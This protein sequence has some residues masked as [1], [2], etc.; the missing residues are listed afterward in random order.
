MTAPLCFGL[1]VTN[2]VDAG[3]GI[4]VGETPVILGRSETARLQ[5]QDPRVSRF[6]LSAW[7]VEGVVYVVTCP[8]AGP[9]LFHGHR[10]REARLGPGD[11]I[12]IGDTELTVVHELPRR[13]GRGAPRYE[14]PPPLP[15]PA[16]EVQGLAAVATLLSTLRLASSSEEFARDLRRA[17]RKRRIEATVRFA[18]G[19]DLPA[20]S[21]PHRA[22]HRV[23]VA[24][25]VA[26]DELWCPIG[27]VVAPGAPEWMVLRLALPV[28]QLKIEQ[29]LFFI[30]VLPL[31]AHLYSFI[32]AA[33]AEAD[34]EAA[35]EEERERFVGNSPAAGAVRAAIADLAPRRGGVL[36]VG[37]R[38]VG[39]QL[40]ARLLH[41]GGARQGSL[42]V[43]DGGDNDAAGD[44]LR[45]LPE[46]GTLL[47]RHG[48][49]L[50]EETQLRLAHAALMTSTRLVVTVAPGSEL[51]TSL[52]SA[53]PHRIVIPPLSQRREDIAPLAERLAA[54]VARARGDAVTAIEP[55]VLAALGGLP[56][57]GNAHDIRLHLEKAA[58][59]R[60]SRTGEPASS[61]PVVALPMKAAALERANYRAAWR[62]ARGDRAAVAKLLDLSV[63]SVCRKAPVE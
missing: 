14:P 11:A 63:V 49:R 46:D 3:A 43:I 41:A 4:A 15:E 53:L 37:E 21:Y 38:G 61:T 34:A 42:V 20:T 62:K 48:E 59:E 5:L 7:C 58:A 29:T 36:I 6:H 39:K 18:A 45:Q 17:L 10:A 23:H 25:D 26:G 57:E 51:A 55:E 44:A 9:L 12:W 31:V 16:N 35:N 32:A 13:D 24:H 19:G 8:E 54:E 28:G 1:R 50:T 33:E 30:A 27:A 22:F 2:G 40:V 56:L 52:R 60:A 47:V